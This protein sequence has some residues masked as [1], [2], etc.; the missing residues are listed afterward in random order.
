MAY[1]PCHA[2]F[3][4]FTTCYFN[5]MGQVAAI[6]IDKTCLL[7]RTSWKLTSKYEY[8]LFGI[9][10]VTISIT[11]AF[12]IAIF[13]LI[14]VP[15]E[16]AIVC[17]LDNLFCGNIHQFSSLAGFF[18]VFLECVILFC[19]IAMIVILKRHIRKQLRIVPMIPQ[20][21]G[22]RT[23]PARSIQ[24]TQRHE[25]LNYIVRCTVTV[26]II[27]GV[28]AFCV[29]PMNLGFFMQGL[30]L[31]RKTSRTT[32]HVFLVLSCANS[33]IN[34]IIYCFRVPEMKKL[35]R[36]VF[37]KIRSL[38]HCGS[39]HGTNVSLHTIPHTSGPDRLSVPPHH[40]TGTRLFQNPSHT[41][42]THVS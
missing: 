14:A 1:W 7:F 2:R 22:D 12:T 35:I 24:T 19:C 20:T 25:S 42:V 3:M 27:V 26:G 36:I 8:R 16:E 15:Q 5:S 11:T 31:V 18:A 40:R 10:A 9:F 6:C 32:R 37:D 23:I 34:P 30:R 21:S 41:Q 17:E 33:A 28:F 13:F 4:F 29:T 39:G 38:C